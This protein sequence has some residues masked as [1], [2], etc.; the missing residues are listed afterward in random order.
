MFLTAVLQ[1][2]TDSHGSADRADT[3]LS[4]TSLD[5]TSTTLKRLDEALAVPAQERI[6][7]LPAVHRS[8]WV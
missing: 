2:H 8:R 7:T 6:Q 4:D 1:G 5:D 3:T